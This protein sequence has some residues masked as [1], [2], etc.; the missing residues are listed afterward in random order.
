MCFT[1]I[2]VDVK[3]KWQ[4]NHYIGLCHGGCAFTF[5]VSLASCPPLTNL[6]AVLCVR[7]D[8]DVVKFLFL[9]PTVLCV[10]VDVNLKFCF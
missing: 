8:N 1:F 7:V 6:A 9:S 5:E 4:F 10:R 2:I 3:V